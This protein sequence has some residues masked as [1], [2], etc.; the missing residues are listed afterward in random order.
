MTR[1]PTKFRKTRPAYAAMRRSSASSREV[2][3]ESGFGEAEVDAL[4]ARGVVR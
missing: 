2:L 4:M 3:E 1:P